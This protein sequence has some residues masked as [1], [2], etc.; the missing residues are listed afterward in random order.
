MP[1]TASRKA[2]DTDLSEDES[3]DLGGLDG[4][5]GFNIRLAHTA[6]YRDFAAS[7]Q[8]LDLTQK[9][10]ATLW[11]IGANAGVSQAALAAQL[12]MDRAT[13]MAIIDRLQDAG[14]VVRE[15][16]TSDRRRHE[17]YLTPAG[18]RVLTKARAAI[19]K[20]EKRFTSKFTPAEMSALM[21]ALRKIAQGA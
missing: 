3:L 2:A 1:R 8:E 12:N 21:S 11:L 16:S 10:T 15:R 18:Q 6:M 4:V 9:Q 13:M 20:H 19:A 17:L 7:L 14:L 5:L